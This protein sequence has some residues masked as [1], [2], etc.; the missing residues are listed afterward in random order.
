MEANDLEYKRNIQDA[1][2]KAEKADRRLTEFQELLKDNQKYKKEKERLLEEKKKTD[3]H[4]EE[5]QK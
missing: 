1:R 2:K 5:L 4:N 3:T